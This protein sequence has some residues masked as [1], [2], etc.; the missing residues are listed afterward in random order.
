MA[1]A[2]QRGISVLFERLDTGVT[3]TD[4]ITFRNRQI[5]EQ[6][7]EGPGYSVGVFLS[8]SI[9]TLNRCLRP[10]YF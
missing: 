1:W 8:K 10:N 3:G 5:Y 6:Q 9:T 7:N 4:N 2:L